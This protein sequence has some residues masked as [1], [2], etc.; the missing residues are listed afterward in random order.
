MKWFV[1]ILIVNLHLVGFAY[2]GMVNLAWDYT[3]EGQTGFRIY[4]G[5]I[6]QASIPAPVNPNGTDPRPYEQVI[7]IPEAAGEEVRATS[8]SLQPG[9]YY[10]RATAYGDSGESNFSNEVVVNVSHSAPGNL[11][12][13]IIV[14]GP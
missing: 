3:D 6:S 7:D 2:A 12:V 11:R 9:V 1:W 4:Y 14:V 13:T 8:F 5:K 10:V